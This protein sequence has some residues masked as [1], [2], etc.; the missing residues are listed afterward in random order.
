MSSLGYFQFARRYFGNHFCS[1]FLRLLRCFSS[2]CLP[3]LPMISANDFLALP[4]MGYPIQISPDLY[5]FSSSPK[6][7]AAFHVFL[8]LLTPRHPPFALNS[9]VTTLSFFVLNVFI[10]LYFQRS[11]GGERVR[12]DD[13]LRAR[14][15]LSQLSYTPYL[16]Y[17][18]GW[19]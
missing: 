8:R 2:P 5:L 18:P 11:Y 3:H 17:G 13:L 10:C 6:L 1:L 14:Q 15:V 9:L 4:K 7:F 12:T 16:F 19:T